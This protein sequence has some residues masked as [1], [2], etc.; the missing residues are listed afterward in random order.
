MSVDLMKR[1]PIPPEGEPDNWWDRWLKRHFDDRN[2]VKS[3]I[4]PEAKIAARRQVF[5]RIVKDW[6]GNLATTILLAAMVALLV[7]IFAV[8][9]V[10]MW[11]YGT[12]GEPNVVCRLAKACPV[13]E[14]AK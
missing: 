13:V 14:I 7:A 8:Y 12:T 4:G 1:D 2:M 6:I 5:W 10:G 9:A 11:Q 3:A